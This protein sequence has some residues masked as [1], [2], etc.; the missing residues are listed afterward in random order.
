[1]LIPPWL[2]AAAAGLTLAAGFG[3]GW[4]VRDWKADSDELAATKD[5]LTREDKA[6]QQGLD[7]GKAYATFQAGNQQQ[8]A[9]DRN[10]I[11][12]TYREVRVPADCAVPAAAAGVLEQGVNRANAAASG[13]PGIALPATA[14]APAPADRP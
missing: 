3:A 7:Q 4:T 2:Y 8:A 12:E 9:T 11:R 13:Q 5:A 10:T 1:M 14:A 6:R